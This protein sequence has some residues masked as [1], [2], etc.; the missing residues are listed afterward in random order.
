[1]VQNQILLFS[2]EIAFLYQKNKI[3]VATQ[4]IPE[5]VEKYLMTN[6]FDFAFTPTKVSSKNFKIPIKKFQKSK[7]TKVKHNFNYFLLQLE[8]VR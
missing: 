6:L 1:M 5:C 7:S 8:Q 3:R 2:D 4:I